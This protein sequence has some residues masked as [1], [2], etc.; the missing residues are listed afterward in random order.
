M[1]FIYRGDI[2]LFEKNRVSYK[3]GAVD[4]VHENYNYICKIKEKYYGNKTDKT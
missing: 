4:L 1:P 3:F 2:E